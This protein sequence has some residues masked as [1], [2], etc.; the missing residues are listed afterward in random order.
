MEDIPASYGTPAISIIQPW[1]WLIANGHKPVENRTWRTSYR[2][3]IL[4]HA[5]KARPDQ[6]GYDLYSI[7]DI[8][9][10]PKLPP[11]NE[12]E[13]GGIVGIAHLV[14][15]VA[16]HPS[17]WFFGPW[18]FVLEGARPVP[19][20]PCRGQLGIFRLAVDGHAR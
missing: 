2:G 17:P 19:F 9:A 18:G 8:T 6:N 11:P 12:L 14:D 20:R 4:I 15:C 13:R 16:S 1:A 3:P 10:G 7:L 5:G